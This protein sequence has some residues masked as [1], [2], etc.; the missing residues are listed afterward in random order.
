MDEEEASERLSKTNLRHIISYEVDEEAGTA[1]V[2]FE[3]LKAEEPAEDED[4]EEPVE[5]DEATREHYTRRARAAL[6]KIKIIND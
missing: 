4:D 2:V 5:D 6:A 3:L 1:T